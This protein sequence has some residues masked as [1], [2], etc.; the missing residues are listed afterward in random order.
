MI[1]ECNKSDVLL[2]IGTGGGENLLEISSSALMLIG[3]D[4]SLSMIETAQTNLL[5][6]SNQNVR[7]F[8]MDAD[9]LQ[10]PDQLFDVTSCCHSPFNPSEV[11]RV[12]REKG[13]FLT[14][15]V[16]EHDK[17][18][19]K[20]TFGRGQSIHTEDGILKNHYV[21]EL[22]EAGFSDV[23]AFEYDVKQYYETEDD[24]IFLLT[25][26]PIIPNFGEKKEDF[27]LL[28]QF[29]EENRT[30]KGIVTNSKRFMIVARK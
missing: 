26:T 19:L 12:L 27:K 5:K 3:I 1:N 16:S 9:H 7:F 25:H 10:F 8:Q 15:Q 20:E 29:I 21:N 14:Q 2:D 4:L 17:Y 30:N 22:Q 23:N 13:I 11:A 18:N 6:S 28:E 24:L